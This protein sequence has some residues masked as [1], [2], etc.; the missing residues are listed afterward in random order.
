MQ[1]VIRRIVVHHSASHPAS[2][3]CEL[4]RQ[5]HTSPDNPA[6]QFDDI[7]YHFVIECLG[8]VKIGRP[9]TQRGAHVRGRNTGSVGICVVGDNTVAGREWNAEQIGALVQ[10]VKAIRTLYGEKLPVLRHL[11]L[12]PTSECPGVDA[13]AW[14]E[15]LERFNEG[16]EHV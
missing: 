12:D 8:E 2:T 1:H 13:R 14:A 3:T 11:E 16:E 9:I 10:S 15:M 4:I 5:W 7:G 6:G